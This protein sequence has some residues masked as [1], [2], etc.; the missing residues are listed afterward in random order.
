METQFSK[1]R[2]DFTQIVSGL[3]GHYDFL[4]ESQAVKKGEMSFE[5]ALELVREEAFKE[6]GILG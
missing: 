4:K 3:L 1:S 6:Q 2:D 5:D